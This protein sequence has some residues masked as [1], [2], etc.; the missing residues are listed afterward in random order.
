MEELLTDYQKA[1]PAF[2][3]VLWERK[4]MDEEALRVRFCQK[5]FNSKNHID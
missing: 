3:T 5:K 4:S 2:A 1:A